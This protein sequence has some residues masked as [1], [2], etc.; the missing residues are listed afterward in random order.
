LE[1]ETVLDIAGDV[2]TDLAGRNSWWIDRLIKFWS[3]ELESAT[4]P[5]SE[6]KDDNSNLN[7]INGLKING[8]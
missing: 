4:W 8:S 5:N 1:I 2:I 7:G 6:F 3:E